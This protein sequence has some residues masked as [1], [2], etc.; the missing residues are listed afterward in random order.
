MFCKENT[1]RHISVV[2]TCQIISELSPN[3]ATVMYIIFENRRLCDKSMK[4]LI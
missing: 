1:P 3:I 4:Q 2:A